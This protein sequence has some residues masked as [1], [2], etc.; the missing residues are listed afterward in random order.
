[1]CFKSSVFIQLGN[2]KFVETLIKNGANVSFI[3]H[4]GKS[5]LHWAAL[6]G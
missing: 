6:L 1:M 4:D 5:A 3:D 2:D